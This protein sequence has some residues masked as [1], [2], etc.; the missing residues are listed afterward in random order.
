M[1]KVNNHLPLTIY[2]LPFSIN[3]EGLNRNHLPLT[4]YHLPFTDYRLPDTD[5]LIV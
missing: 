5:Y 3:A 1:V 4:I 2:H